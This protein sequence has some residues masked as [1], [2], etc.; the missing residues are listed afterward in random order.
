MKRIHILLLSL[1]AIVLGIGIF[2]VTAIQFLEVFG[3]FL[4]ICGALGLGY[5]F[6]SRLM[7]KSRE[8]WEASQPGMSPVAKVVRKKMPFRSWAITLV[9]SLIVGIPC[10]MSYKDQNDLRLIIGCLATAMAVYA[11][12]SLFCFWQI[13]RD[14]RRL[15]GHQE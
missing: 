9:I 4:C 15:L 14:E 5:L 3:F 7:R 12:F 1:L 6:H 10:L 2:W 11:A 8:A 13:K